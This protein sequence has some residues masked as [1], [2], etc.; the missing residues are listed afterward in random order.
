MSRLFE[1]RSRSRSDGPWV[2]VSDLMAG[3][4]LVFLS[5][6]IFFMI[7]VERDK[8]RIENV[9]EDYRAIRQD[10]YEALEEEFVL[11]KAQWGAEID[12]ETLSVRFL[13]DEEQP[14]IKLFF[15]GGDPNVQAAGR[16]ILTEFFPRY[17]G[18][19]ME[20]RFRDHITE[21]RIEGH[22]SLEWLGSRSVRDAYLRNL[23]LSQSRTRSVLEFV[24]ALPGVDE[25]W[26]SWLRPRLTA[27]GLSSSRP[28]LNPDG[29]PDPLMSRRV[30]FRV[31]TDA[32]TQIEAILD[33]ARVQHEAP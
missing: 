27:N 25:H 5:I 14:D 28:V 15:K 29:R 9:A 2:S 4:M 7:Q 16:K 1:K 22:T 3:L 31:V 30:E 26:E 20:D 32:D 13:V 19:L 11:D 12:R 23:E 18:V 21:V 17:L 8:R 33:L 10:L 24:M 6:A